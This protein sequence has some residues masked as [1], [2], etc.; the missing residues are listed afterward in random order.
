MSGNIYT[1]DE[2]R[3]RNYVVSKYN[4]PLMD[5]PRCEYGYELNLQN[6][7]NVFDENSRMIYVQKRET[8]LRQVKDL[9]K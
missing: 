6:D 2:V 3:I 8:E 7:I 4:V 9:Y 5:S 1:E